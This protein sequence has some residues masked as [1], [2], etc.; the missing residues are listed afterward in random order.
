LR[1][2]GN[3]LRMIEKKGIDA[4]VANCAP[5]RAGLKE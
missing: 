3:G 4:I 1:V 5:G 2:S